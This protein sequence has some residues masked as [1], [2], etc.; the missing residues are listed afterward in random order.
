[1]FGINIAVEQRK[2]LQHDKIHGLSYKPKQYDDE[3]LHITD[4][5]INAQAECEGR[6]MSRAFKSKTMDFGKRM[7]RTYQQGDD[8]FP[9]GNDHRAIGRNW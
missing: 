6:F 3:V 9:T 4:D 2:Q 1:M 5:D 8:T 7:R